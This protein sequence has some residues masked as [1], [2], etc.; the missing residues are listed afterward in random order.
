[1]IASMD[2]I[3]KETDKLDLELEEAHGEFDKTKTILEKK[4]AFYS[5]YE[6]SHRLTRIDILEVQNK[7]NWYMAHLLGLIEHED[8]VNKISELTERV[9]K[10][11]QIAQIEE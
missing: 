2:T 11:E 1:M 9:N 10:L 7:K 4:I 8:L 5:R 6:N 3:R